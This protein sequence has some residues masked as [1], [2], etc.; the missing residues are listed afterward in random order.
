VWP[1]S[2]TRSGPL[3]TNSLAP[4]LVRTVTG[5]NASTIA[6][7]SSKTTDSAAR[8]RTSGARNVQ[9]LDLLSIA[10]VKHVFN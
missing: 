8:T 6:V 2:S 10:E 3:A 7:R 4:N 1:I 5:A 9:M